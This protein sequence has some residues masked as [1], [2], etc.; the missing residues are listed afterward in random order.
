MEKFQPTKCLL[1]TQMAVSVWTHLLTFPFDWCEEEC[2]LP[3][4]LSNSATA[5][6]SLPSSH[7][8]PLT[9]S[10]FPSPLIT[11]PTE[12]IHSWGPPCWFS[13]KHKGNESFVASEELDSNTAPE[14]VP[15]NEHPWSA[16]AKEKL[17]L[18]VSREKRREP[19]LPALL[20]LH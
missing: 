20:Q 12:L 2:L 5:P 14:G 9:C 17:F 10:L 6:Q 16:E 11:A 7:L 3:W 8:T 13:F 18:E 1:Y 4:A 15:I 19:G